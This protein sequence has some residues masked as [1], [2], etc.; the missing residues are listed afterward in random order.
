M[1]KKTAMLLAATMICA[2]AFVYG[3]KR[4]EQGE[5][6]K[7]EPK[8]EQKEVQSEEPKKDVA[9]MYYRERAVKYRGPGIKENE[10][11]YIGRGELSRF[12]TYAVQR[13]GDDI[14]LL[15][16]LGRDKEGNIVPSFIEKYCTYPLYEELSKD[17]LAESAYNS[18]MTEIR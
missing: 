7:E 18:L 6:P 8:E 4:E 11:E 15:I 12:V 13:K 3:S 10:L 16:D 9:K 2:G 5:D 14:Y 17:A 1:K